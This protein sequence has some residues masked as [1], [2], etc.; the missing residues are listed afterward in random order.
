MKQN[1]T[2]SWLW[3][4][5]LLLSSQMN[6]AT[7]YLATNGNDNNNGTSTATPWRTI[8]KLNAQIANNSIVSGDFIYFRKGD[9]FEGE[10]KLTGNQ[11]NISFNQWGSALN[12]PI[13][14]GTR[15]ITG[16]TAV[17][18]RPNLY[19]A[20]LDTVPEMVFRNGQILT[21]A[22][23]PNKD[24]LYHNTGSST[25][26]S[27]TDPAING[28]R[29]WTG[30]GKVVMRTEDWMYETREVLSQNNVT[31]TITFDD[32]DDNPID[33]RRPFYFYNTFAALDTINEWFY[34]TASP[35]NGNKLYVYSFGTPTNIEASIRP[36][37]IGSKS[38]RSNISINNLEFQG[39]SN[40]AIYLHD[41]AN[42]NNKI[43]FCQFVNCYAGVDVRGQNLAISGN[44]FS[45]IFYT[46]ILGDDISG[47]TTIDNNAMTGIGRLTYYNHYASA[48]D[49]QK[50]RG[51]AI[52][53]NIV[54]SCGGYAI[55]LTRS[56]N[57]RIDRNIVSNA[58]MH[59]NDAGGIYIWGEFI[60]DLFNGTIRRNI[61]HTIKGDYYGRPADNS[62]VDSLSYIT[63]GIY[64][65]NAC[66][67]ILVDSN[68]VYD[69]IRNGLRVNERSNNITFRANTVYNCGSGITFTDNNP[70][71]P[72]SNCRLEG[73][74]FFALANNQMPFTILSNT[75]NRRPFSVSESNY[76]FNPF[77]F[78]TH[79]ASN[80]ATYP[81]L[82]LRDWQ[83]ANGGIDTKS[84]A[85]WFQGRSFFNTGGELIANGSFAS[86]INDWTCFVSNNFGTCNLGTANGIAG[87]SNGQA[88]IGFSGGNSE[89]N[90]YMK[91]NFFTVSPGQLY[92]L[93]VTLRGAANQDIRAILQSDIFQYV[94]FI[95][96]KNNATRTFNIQFRHNGKSNT[97]RL[98]FAVLNPNVTIWVDD[99]SLR[100]I[101]LNNSNPK[102]DYP[103]FVNPSPNTATINLG[104]AGTYLNLDSANVNSSTLTLPPYGSRILIR[105]SGVVNS[106]L[107]GKK[108]ILD[109]VAQI[110]NQ[111]SR[112]EWVS[113]AGDNGDY[114]DVEKLNVQTGVF[115]TIETIPHRLNDN[116]IAQYVTFDD[117]IASGDNIYRIKMVLADG[118]VQLSEVKTL[119]FGNMDNINIFPN[120]VS[121][122]LHIAAKGYEGKAV[123]IQLY[124]M[125][126]NLTLSKRFATV[127]AAP[128]VIPLSEDMK[129]GQYVVRISSEQKRDV[130]K[131]FSVGK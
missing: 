84:K 61:V 34:G 64:V 43:R 39:Q 119:N 123:T 23:Y 62:F 53:Q 69:V 29:I 46:G 52:S 24:F 67:N 36:H 110:D 16:W 105:K 101:A 66:Q 94:S 108:T 20:T 77:D 115:E 8:A 86:G 98:V 1:N 58:S 79:L 4:S 3:L 5:F 21:P 12:R 131:K 56:N 32:V 92:N 31:N 100:P 9:V 126:G 96:V 93:K 82:T 68:T 49:I 75:N 91:S 95:P 60:K 74:T 7:Y 59:I 99:V 63:D 116:A 10:V 81:R 109:V 11:T 85:A 57:F 15:A 45:N 80:Y 124:D 55:R 35:V 120:P 71:D 22:R 88:R 25:P 111:R 114:Y 104:A 113:N 128:F 17:P 70:A 41:G 87:M 44:R 129:V 125:L 83:T 37:G 19:Y 40:A 27:L 121:D 38:T 127:S 106:N 42:V 13:I 18:N 2:F 33:L 51:L 78:Y 72:I 122:V 76:Y 90:V 65:D 14:K 47:A 54:D 48:M 97:A 6:A 89:T 117:K 26:T 30:G 102:M 118:T 28:A 103:L 130:F 50:A 73:N 112:I 107:L